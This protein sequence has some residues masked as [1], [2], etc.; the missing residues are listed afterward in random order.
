[1]SWTSELRLDDLPGE[2]RL[3]AA[4][5]T[6]GAHRFYTAAQLLQ[7]KDLEQ[8]YLDQVESILRCSQKHCRG[9]VRLY[10]ADPGDTEAFVGGL[11]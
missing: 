5:K 1:M 8:A 9:H 10:R 2:E 6:C 3:E 11:A 7:I 4:C